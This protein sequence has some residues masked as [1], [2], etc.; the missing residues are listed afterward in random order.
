M[1]DLESRAAE[2]VADAVGKVE[3]R[4]LPA[5]CKAVMRLS[6]NALALHTSHD[7]AAETHI[8]LGRQHHERI[9]RGYR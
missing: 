7:E 4:L 8:G 9:G 2:L 6:G 5:F 1:S 3:R